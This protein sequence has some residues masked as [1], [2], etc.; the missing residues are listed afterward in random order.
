MYDRRMNISTTPQGLGT[1]TYLTQRP[2]VCWSMLC[3]LKGR[4]DAYG[5]LEL[6]IFLLFL[7]FLSLFFFPPILWYTRHASLD[8]DN[9]ARAGVLYSTA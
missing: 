4:A 6:A 5:K 9:R 2:T 7:F 8:G 3:N 1:I